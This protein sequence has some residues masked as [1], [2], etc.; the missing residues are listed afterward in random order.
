MVKK[1]KREVDLLDAQKEFEHLKRPEFDRLYQNMKCPKSCE[2]RILNKGN[3]TPDNC[4]EID[5]RRKKSKIGI[6]AVKI[7][8]KTMR[9]AVK[10]LSYRDKKLLDR[11]TTYNTIT[12]GFHWRNHERPEIKQQLESLGRQMPRLSP[13]RRPRITLKKV[14]KVRAQL[15]LPP[16]AGLK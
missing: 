2:G 4:T 8:A 12:S 10:K 11:V 5:K 15:G 13:G 1:P 16:L 7:A 14:N 6:A 3:C 9:P